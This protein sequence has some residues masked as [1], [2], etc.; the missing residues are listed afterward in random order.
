MLTTAITIL[1]AFVVLWLFA[2]VKMVRPAGS[3]PSP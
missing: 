1:V 2:S 3:W